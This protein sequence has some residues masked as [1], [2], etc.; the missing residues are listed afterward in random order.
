M[1]RRDGT[2]PVGTGRRDGSG[3]GKGRRTGTGSGSKT[4]GQKGGC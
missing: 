1:G 3:K 2:G 4:G